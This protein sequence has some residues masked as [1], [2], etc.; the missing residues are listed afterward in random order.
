[1]EKSWSRAPGRPWDLHLFSQ[2]S[3]S[4]SQ[5]D[6]CIVDTVNTDTPTTHRREHAMS[7]WY[8][9]P[10][11]QVAQRPDPVAEHRPEAL[12]VVRQRRRERVR[13]FLAAR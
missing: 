5:D 12:Q 1:M 2:W 13:A 10:L 9:P 11:V 3:P 4:A 7:Y 6:L 8:Y